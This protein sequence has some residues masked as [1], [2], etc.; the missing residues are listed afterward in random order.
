MLPEQSIK[1]LRSLT[2]HFVRIDDQAT[3]HRLVQPQRLELITGQR[4]L[5][6]QQRQKHNSATASA[7]LTRHNT[8]QEEKPSIAAG[9]RSSLAGIRSGSELVGDGRVDLYAGL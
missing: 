3:R 1:V 6:P 8:T 4:P 9:V 7:L 2:Q 5:G